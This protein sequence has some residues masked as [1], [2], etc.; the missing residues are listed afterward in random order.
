MK[1][2]RMKT[3]QMHNGSLILVNAR[4]ACAAELS[5]DSLQA[6]C[7]G[8][9]ILL[10]R[11]AARALAALMSELDGWE[12]ITAVSGWRPGEE[13]KEL[14]NG[15]ILEHGYE[16]TRKFVALPGCSEHQTG[17]AVDL[18]LRQEKID[19]ICPEFPYTGICQSFRERASAYGFVERYPRGKESVTVIGWEPWHFRYVGLPH[20][21][22]MEERGLVLEEYLDLLR[23]HLFGKNPLAVRQGDWN[24]E[25]SF[26]KARGGQSCALEAEGNSFLTVSGNNVDGFIITEWRS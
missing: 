23:D 16:Y 4:Q 7:P 26:L 6:V 17:L 13:Q 22:I 21:G 1:T 8:T 2:Y 19:F 25:V 18:G 11:R 3:E 10:E 5:A 24:A 20:A 14:Y 12:Q 15:S 9:D